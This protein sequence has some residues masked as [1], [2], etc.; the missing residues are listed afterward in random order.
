MITIHSAHPFC[1]PSFPASRVDLLPIFLQWDWLCAAEKNPTLFFTNGGYQNRSWKGTKQQTCQL[2]FQTS[3][4]QYSQNQNAP[5]HSSESN[6][7]LGPEASGQSSL[8]A[9]GPRKLIPTV[10]NDLSFY[11]SQSLCPFLCSQV[12]FLCFFDMVNGQMTGG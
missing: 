12:T 7:R 6:K 8:A 11:P 10:N 1:C 4:W 3:W 5:I 2:W 9:P